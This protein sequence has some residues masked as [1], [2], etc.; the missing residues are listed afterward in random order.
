MIK[1]DKENPEASK[2]YTRE[3]KR[4][5]VVVRKCFVKKLFKPGACNFITIDFGTDVFLCNLKNF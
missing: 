3:N 1:T 2:I 5:Q 4:S